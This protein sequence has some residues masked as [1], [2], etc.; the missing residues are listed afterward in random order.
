M[1]P[2]VVH[3]KK[4]TYINL[5]GEIVPIPSI[6]APK[7]Q[8][9]E[10]LGV[11]AS[12]SD[13][14][15]DEVVSVVDELMDRKTELIKYLSSLAS[16]AAASKGPNDQH[17]ARAYRKA[18]AALRP[19]NAPLVSAKKGKEITGIG[20]S[21]SKK[22]EDFYFGVTSNPE[23]KKLR[24]LKIVLS[25]IWGA[26]PSDID[27]WIFS[28]VTS[29]DSLRDL[30]HEGQ[31]KVSQQQIIGINFYEDFLL[32][33]PRK[34]AGLFLDLISEAVEKVDPQA[35]TI[36]AG[37]YAR[38]AKEISDIDILII[39][40]SITEK[41]DILKVIESLIDDENRPKE[42]DD[43]NH[44]K[45]QNKEKSDDD[46]LIM[47][48]AK[49]EKFSN[50]RPLFEL[51]IGT[52]GDHQFMGAMAN[53]LGFHTP[54]RRVDIFLATPSEKVFALFQ[55]TSSAEYNRMMRYEASKR[56]LLLNQRGLW[57]P[58][59]GGSKIRLN[60]GVTTEEE[61]FDRLGVKWVPVEK[62]V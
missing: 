37:S 15:Y 30:V 41:E 59:S 36:L 1:P 53:P 51:A 43:E 49:P 26:G 18:I 13:V 60:T 23:D 54:F 9:R 40:D 19:I 39:S 16:E 48:P 10:Y 28:G 27:Q 57:G 2:K 33:I 22:I 17:R 44:P 7:D 58:P 34:E 61:L 62:R 35:E 14:P 38:G 42:Q 5:S 25:K 45:K 29:L 12:S 24:D 6:Q 47:T 31:I 20:A 8:I 55:Y 4:T 32:K 50:G 11:C 21:I 3:Q 52:L 46:T 56:G